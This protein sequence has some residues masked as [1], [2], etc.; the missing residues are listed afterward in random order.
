MS[1]PATTSPRPTAPRSGCSARISPSPWPALPGTWSNQAWAATG[2]ER[3]LGIALT[4]RAWEL[5]ADFPFP[6]P[7]HFDFQLGGQRV[8]TVE[9]KVGLK[10]RY[11]VTVAHPGIDRRLVLAQAI[12]LDALQSR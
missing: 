1:G 6:I 7:Y 2:S 10:D 8:V 9:K 11:V 4:R 5:V 3:S 12:A